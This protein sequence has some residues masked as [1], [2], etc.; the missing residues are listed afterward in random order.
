MFKSYIEVRNWLENFI[1]LV[2]GKE[3]LGL[4]R[5]ENLLEKVGN[6]EKKFK[7]IHVG[8]TSGKG[9][10]CFYIC[11]ILQKRGFKVGLHLSPHLIDIRERMQI[12]RYQ[13]SDIRH[14]RYSKSEIGNRKFGNL[15]PLM[16]FIGLAGEIKPVVDDIIANEPQKTPSYFEILVAMSFLYFAK[17]KVDYAVV[18]VG[19]GGR[20]D[21]TNV[22]VPKVSVITNIGLDHTEIL[23][24]TIEKIAA[25]KAGIIKTQVPVVTASS[26]K[27]LKIIKKV[28]KG[29]KSLLI[30]INT[31]TGKISSE[32]DYFDSSFEP[33]DTFGSNLYYA[34]RECILLAICAILALKIK[35]KK[36]L[37]NDVLGEQFPG[38]FELIDRNVVID[39]AHNPDKIR[40][41]IEFIR[42][43]PISNSQFS[44]TLVVAFK[45][46]KNWEETID[47]LVKNLPV[48]AVIATKY[49]AVTDTGKGSAV[50]PR[51]I[52]KYLKRAYHLQSTV[53]D[54]SQGAVYSALNGKSYSKGSLILITGSLYLVGEARTL[55][56]LPDF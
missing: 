1:P 31:Q 9:T 11:R 33:F 27:A 10:T 41:L 3:E 13:K 46:G 29:E 2:Y 35:V 12:F 16:R 17:E 5:I 28:V 50:N 39:G 56:K 20:L 22:L 24:K 14:Q 40:A 32:I 51:E 8:G 53:V 38:R 25:E 49:Q 42:E 52:E 6:P 30:T 44:I 19:L 34:Q 47:I 21:A 26:A 36:E 23:G 55:W 18:E 45:S 4:T 48:N 43:F 54:N 15:M 7:S 37:I